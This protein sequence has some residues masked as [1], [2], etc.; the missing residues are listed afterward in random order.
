MSIESISKDKKQHGD[1][2]R[3]KTCITWDEDLSKDK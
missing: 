2:G 3:T 1:K